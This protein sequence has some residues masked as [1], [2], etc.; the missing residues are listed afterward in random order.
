MRMRI[1]SMYMYMWECNV[2]SDVDHFMCMYRGNLEVSLEMDSDFQNRP[3]QQ[4][5]YSVRL[6]LM[7]DSPSHT[8][9]WD[10]GLCRPAVDHRCFRLM[11]ATVGCTLSELV[12]LV[13]A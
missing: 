9:L 6:S 12:M 8:P 1:P 11:L 2:Y 5:L 4:C 13:N 7:H 10:L 3:F